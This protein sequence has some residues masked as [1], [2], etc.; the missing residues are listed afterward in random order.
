MYT[1]EGKIDRSQAVND[2]MPLVRRHALSLQVRL[3]PSVELDD[4]IQAGMVGLLDAFNRYDHEQGAS[5]S[6]YAS[7][8]I[9]GSMIDELRSRDWLPRSVRR[10]SRRIE[11]AMQRLANEYGRAPSEREIATELDMPI[12]EYHRLLHD[13]NNGYLA[14]Y[15]DNST[16]ETEASVV[17]DGL[18][19]YVSPAEA[20]F[21]Y[22][23]RDELAA[24]IDKLPEREKMLLGLYYQEQLN[25]KEIGAVLEVSESRVC[26][27]HS[28]AVSRLR[29][30]M[31]ED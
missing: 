19:P 8:R 17:P 26:Q 1:A 15:E 10:G 7:Q 14:T 4:L 16:A 29:V 6:T 24:A 23:Q 27:L 18:D 28:Q 22:A 20:T 21:A 12:E 13:V 3:P 25:L 5:F 31:A 9:K 2:Y 11:Q 30:T